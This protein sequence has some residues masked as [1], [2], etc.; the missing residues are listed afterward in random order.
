MVLNKSIVSIVHHSY[1][2]PSGVVTG[3]QWVPAEAT[4]ILPAGA[5]PAN[6]VSVESSLTPLTSFLTE[7]HLSPNKEFAASWNRGYLSRD[8]QK[9]L[10]EW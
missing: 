5:Q 10:K 9:A 4:Q 2:T 1:Q 3:I 7:S 8:D 6:A